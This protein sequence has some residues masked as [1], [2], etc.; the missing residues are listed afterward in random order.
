MKKQTYFTA[1]NV[2]FLGILTA[3]TVVLQ[4]FASG[5]NV[6]GLT[7]NFSLI[8]IVLAG[9]FLGW[10]GG[11]F[12]GLIAGLV[13]FITCAVMGKEPFTYAMFQAS[14]VIL[15]LVCLLKT[16]VAG[17]VSGLLYRLIRKKS[18]IAASYV[19]SA[20]VPVVNTG[21]YLVGLVLMKGDVAAFFSIEATIGAVLALAVSLIWLNFVLELAVNIIVAPALHAVVAVVEKRISK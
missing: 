19:A 7:L 17:I 14:P 3:L 10:I 6:F 1:R 5:V 11:G 12:M 4:L 9:I 2:A 16:T 13:T 20:V 18:T 21:L 15:T 8:P